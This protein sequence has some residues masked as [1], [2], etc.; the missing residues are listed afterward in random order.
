MTKRKGGGRPIS[1]ERKYQLFSLV[2]SGQMSLSDL[3][4]QYRVTYVA[5]TD[6]Y[7]NTADIIKTMAAKARIEKLMKLT[8]TRDIA[9]QR[10]IMRLKPKPKMTRNRADAVASFATGYE[11]EK[12]WARYSPMVITPKRYNAPRKG[13]S[14]GLIGKTEY[15]GFDAFNRD[16]DNLMK[17]LLK[18]T[19]KRGVT[20]KNIASK[21]KQVKAGVGVIVK[22]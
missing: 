7:S 10:A 3:K 17:S 21:L 1:N 8:E 9:A 22:R 5:A 18:M 12:S 6:E 20:G 15:I 19:K 16:F 13:S 11:G 14:R 2:H 4:S